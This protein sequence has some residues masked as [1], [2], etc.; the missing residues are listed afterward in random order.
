MQVHDE[1]IVETP[2]DK[3]EETCNILK[4]EM[5]KAAALSVPLLVDANFGKTWFDAK[6]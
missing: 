2:D 4:Q 1:L 6:G 3:A 5:E